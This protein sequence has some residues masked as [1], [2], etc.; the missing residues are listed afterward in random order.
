MKFDIVIPSCKKDQFI[1]NKEIDSIIKF[2][3]DFR[4]IIVISNE[5]LIDRP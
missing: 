1:L 4:R 5:K 2:I 3:K